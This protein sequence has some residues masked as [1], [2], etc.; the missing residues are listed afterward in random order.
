MRST[1]I[2]VNSFL[3]TGHMIGGRPTMGAWVT[4]GLGS[5]SQN[6]PGFVVLSSGVGTSAGSDNY[7]NW[8]CALDVCRHRV[9]KFGR[10]DSLSGQPSRH[11]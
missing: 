5:E 11:E 10:S 4:N 3:F 1:I 6:L 9:L 2:R 7:S 8:F